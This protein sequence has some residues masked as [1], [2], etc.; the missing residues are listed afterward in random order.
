M[1]EEKK[2]DL[3][4]NHSHDGADQHGFLKCMVWAGTGEFGVIQSGDLK[5]YNLSRVSE[6]GPKARSILIEENQG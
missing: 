6:W 5:P 1:A 4:H 3:L 2:D